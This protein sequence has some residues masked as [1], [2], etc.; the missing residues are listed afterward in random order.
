MKCNPYGISSQL[1]SNEPQTIRK[2]EMSN[3]PNAFPDIII[4]EKPIMPTPR[5]IQMTSHTCQMILRTFLDMLV[6]SFKHESVKI[7]N[8]PIF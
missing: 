2:Y 4:N 1:M 5:L 8:T 3:L 6:V 7:N